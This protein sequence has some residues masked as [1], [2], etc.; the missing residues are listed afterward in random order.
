MHAARGRFAP[1]FFCP[2]PFRR[3]R[4][5]ATYKGPNSASQ[6]TLPVPIAYALLTMSL[7][8]SSPPPVEVT[9][10]TDVQQDAPLGLYGCK[11]DSPRGIA[12]YT[13][14]SPVMFSTLVEHLERKQSIEKKRSSAV[15]RRY[16]ESMKGCEEALKR[17]R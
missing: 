17:I 4:G 8:S 3:L 1:M 6:H 13:P 15:V 5:R 9:L 12:D 7:S 14:D 2:N 16:V 10:S 11:P